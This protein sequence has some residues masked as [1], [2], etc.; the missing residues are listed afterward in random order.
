[1]NDKTD[2]NSFL[3]GKRE[4]L[5][6]SVNEFVDAFSLGEAERKKLTS[7]F[8]KNKL[9][10]DKLG[11][12]LAKEY[13]DAYTE[14]LIK[15]SNSKQIEETIKKVSKRIE[16]SSDKYD[17]RV[18]VIARTFSHGIN[19]LLNFNQAREIGI[20]HFKYVGNP[21]TERQFCKKHLNKTY[22]LEYMKTLDNG[23][24]LDVI[25]YA[26]GYNCRHYWLPVIHP[27]AINDPQK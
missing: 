1:M 19:N 11:G 13:K 5:Y 17:Q 10:L 20:T 26:G 4:Q 2:I 23:Q 15:G 8:K 21:I 27:E 22:T 24:H 3:S 25:T 7:A 16:Y 12:T 14:I 18:K 6:I 9:S